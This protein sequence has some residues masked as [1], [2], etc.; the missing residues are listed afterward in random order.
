[1]SLFVVQKSPDAIKYIYKKG[2]LRKIP[3]YSGYLQNFFYKLE[4]NNFKC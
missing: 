3:A 2:N 4:P 1:M